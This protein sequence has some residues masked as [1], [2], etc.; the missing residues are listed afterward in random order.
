MLQE[1][2]HVRIRQH[3]NPLAP[4]FSVCI[5]HPQLHVYVLNFVIVFNILLFF[6]KK[7]LIFVLGD[8]LTSK[9]ITGFC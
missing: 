3:V 7:I 6:K 1:V 5:M 2:G 8:L 9:V 4:S